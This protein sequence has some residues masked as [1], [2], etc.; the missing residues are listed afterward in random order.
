MLTVIYKDERFRE[1]SGSLADNLKEVH[2]LG[3]A[4]VVNEMKSA[5]KQSAQSWERLKPLAQWH[6]R[7]TGNT[8]MAILIVAAAL[9]LTRFASH[10]ARQAEA[11]EPTDAV[12]ANNVDRC[13]L[14]H[15]WLPGTLAE[16][17]KRQR[18]KSSHLRKRCQ[19][20]RDSSPAKLVVCADRESAA[21]RQGN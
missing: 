1:R 17:A 19:C 10:V 3:D 21:V 14:L 4:K 18:K 9:G 11:C 2:D 15:I 20:S 12:A 8:A 13:D 7:S 5:S 6:S 16:L